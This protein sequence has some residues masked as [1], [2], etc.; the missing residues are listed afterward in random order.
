MVQVEFKKVILVPPITT[1]LIGYKF[2]Y[3]P[4]SVVQ[5]NIKDRSQS[6]KSPKKGN[7]SLFFSR[8]NPAHPQ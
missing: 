8:P 4:T 1:D 3:L 7:S 5:Q 2:C 6:S